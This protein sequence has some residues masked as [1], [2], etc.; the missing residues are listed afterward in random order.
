METSP[1]RSGTLE[2]LP[3]IIMDPRDTPEILNR[4]AESLEFR[5]RQYEA[6]AAAVGLRLEELR[7]DQ[8]RARQV[9]DFVAGV[10]RYDDTRL[11]V[12]SPGT[13]TATPPDPG[14]L[15]PG[16]DSLGVETRPLTLEERIE[17][18][19]LLQQELELR[20]QQIRIKAELFRRR[21]RGGEER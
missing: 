14:Q 10:E 18:L 6:Q 21:A 7:Q 15:P 16:A 20:L 8:R 11:P 5:A 1:R 12:V 4:K 17:N 3:E 9:R 13:R 19:G 2:P